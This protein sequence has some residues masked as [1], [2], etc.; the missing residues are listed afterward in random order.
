M[1]RRPLRRPFR[2]KRPQRVPPALRRANELMGAG[3]YP[4]AAFAFEEIALRTEARHGARAPIF[5][6]RAGRAYILSKDVEKGMTHFR[7]GLTMLSAK[8]EWE[9]LHRFG[10]R[11]VNELKELGLKQE[12][13]EIIDLLEKRLPEKIELGQDK[14]R[15]TLPTLCPSCGAPIRSDEVVWI[16]QDTAECAFCGNPVRGED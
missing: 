1:R 6:L 5:H 8:K 10:Q 7:R 12:S 4:E 13:Q 2:G 15:A 16:D 14:S 9:P 11:T 3:N